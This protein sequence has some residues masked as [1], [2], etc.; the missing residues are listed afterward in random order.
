MESVSALCPKSY[1]RCFAS[2]SAPLNDSTKSRRYSTSVLYI[3]RAVSF[4]FHC[5]K[6]SSVNF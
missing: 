6:T 5:L 2:A 1:E 3:I 4:L